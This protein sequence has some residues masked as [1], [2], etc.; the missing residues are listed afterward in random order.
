MTC[1]YILIWIIVHHKVYNVT[2]KSLMEGN[3]ENITSRSD[4][5]YIILCVKI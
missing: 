3:A 5:I 1:I 4:I 2:L